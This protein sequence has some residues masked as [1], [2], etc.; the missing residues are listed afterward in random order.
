LGISPDFELDFALISRW[1]SAERDNGL[2]VRKS[3]KSAGITAQSAG[4][5]A[6]SGAQSHV[7]ARE[8]QISQAN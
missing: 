4:I 1:I 3:A 7:A 2:A 8:Q 5:T 6:Q